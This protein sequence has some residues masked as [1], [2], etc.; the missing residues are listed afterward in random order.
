[1]KFGMGVVPLGTTSKSYFY[2][3]IGDTKVADEEILY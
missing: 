2:H 3:T 1:M